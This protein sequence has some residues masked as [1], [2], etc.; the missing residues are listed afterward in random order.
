MNQRY[1]TTLREALRALFEGRLVVEDVLRAALRANP[2]FENWLSDEV[3]HSLHEDP[4][5]PRLRRRRDLPDAVRARVLTAARRQLQRRKDVVSVSWGVKYSGGLP[6]ESDAIIVWVRD[7]RPPREV[8][9]PIK[10]PLQIRVGGKKVQ[11]ALDVQEVPRAQK[12]WGN[13]IRPGD[14]AQVDVE[15]RVG[16]LSAILDTGEVFFSGH[17]AGARGKPAFAIIPGRGRIPLGPVDDYKDDAEVD[18]AVAGPLPPGDIPFATRNPTRL[19]ELKPGEHNIGVKVLCIDGERATSVDALDVP[20]EFDGGEMMHSMIRL[21]GKVTA[22]GDSG[23]P[24]IDYFGNL[25][26]FVVGASKGKTIVIPAGRVLN[27]LL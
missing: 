6:Q 21:A 5:I 22:K 2:R 9:S 23:A 16:T 27:A 1:G 19:R 24:T 20:A 15:Q 18:G 17:V 4:R 12:Q 3:S 25:I 8:R 26:G 13:Q 7:K 11:V 10:G 14:R